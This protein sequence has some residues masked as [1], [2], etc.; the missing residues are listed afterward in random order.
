M[1]DDQ[2]RQQK[3]DDHD[4]K[5]REKR[6][7][8]GPS[9]SKREQPEAEPVKRKSY[10][11]SICK[12]P[13]HRAPDCKEA[14]AEG[15]AAGARADVILAMKEYYGNDWKMLAELLNQMYVIEGKTKI[16]V[17]GLVDIMYRALEAQANVSVDIVISTPLGE[18]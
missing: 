14:T 12:Q 6:A 7:D 5:E 11:C 2:D 4:R 3:H 15:E 9:D 18:Y 1:E 10:R 16:K 13:G 8:P 17:Q